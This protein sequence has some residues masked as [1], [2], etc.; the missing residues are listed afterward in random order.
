MMA[1]RSAAAAREV[2]NASAQ[3]ARALACI[4]MLRNF[5]TAPRASVYALHRREACLESKGVMKDVE[6]GE[7]GGSGDILCNVC[8]GRK[9][10]AS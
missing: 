1:Q 8:G 7:C 2:E 5:W 6:C 4:G 10:V 3:P 9:A